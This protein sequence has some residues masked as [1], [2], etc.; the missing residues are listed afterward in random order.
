MQYSWASVS[1]SAFHIAVIQPLK[2]KRYKFL[3]G[4]NNQEHKDV[5][6]LCQ[7]GLS[8]AAKPGTNAPFQS[9]AQAGQ[10]PAQQTAPPTILGQ[11]VLNLKPISSYS[12][13]HNFTEL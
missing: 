12:S 7:C 11:K 6:V 8:H 3:S 13:A 5:A 10:S 9:P 1:L 4:I 2:K